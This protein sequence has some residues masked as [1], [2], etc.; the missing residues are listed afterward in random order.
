MQVY[1]AKLEELCKQFP[2]P[3]GEF[4]RKAM[5]IIHDH[6]PEIAK[7]CAMS[8]DCPGAKIFNM[9]SRYYG[10]EN[11]FSISVDIMCDQIGCHDMQ[12]KIKTVQL[13]VARRIEA[14]K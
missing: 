13:R 1:L 5:Q 12:E 6:M 7:E 11:T 3:N 4:E 9:F 2:E 8:V 10:Y 14:Y